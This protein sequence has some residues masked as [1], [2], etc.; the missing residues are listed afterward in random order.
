MNKNALMV[1]GALILVLI[2]LAITIINSKSPSEDV[3]RINAIVGN[4]T[5]LDASQ[6]RLNA[7]LEVDNFA[8]HK[9]QFDSPF[10]KLY[11]ADFD[12]FFHGRIENILNEMDEEVPP[13]EVRIWY[14]YNMGI[15]AKSSNCTV[16][17]DLAGTYIDP[18][19]V[20]LA[21]KLD[22]LIISHSHGDHFDQA[23]VKE[24]I[25]NNAT[26][27]FPG[28]NVVIEKMNGMFGTVPFI[29]R[30]ENGINPAN[31]I[32]QVY[33]INAQDITP[34]KSGETIDING[35]SITAFSA[36]HYIPEIPISEDDDPLFRNSSVSWF[37]VNIS[38]KTI[39]HTGDGFVLEDY[40]V[41]ADKQVDMMA[42]HYQDERSI[43]PY[44]EK[45]PNL[46]LIVPLHL[47]E[48]GHGMKIAEYGLYKHAL[49]NFEDGMFR[50]MA[51]NITTNVRYVPM[52]WG[53]S[54][55]LK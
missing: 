27:I 33:G 46:K 26:V 15:I 21:K 31:A 29:N 37:Y 42:I 20:L 22:V 17:F 14:V 24:A 28:E 25:R 18:S 55:E 40:E 52:I 6:A 8:M 54:I 50:L 16:G 10:P 36:K 1:T 44:Y 11:Q 35:I 30:D 41:G 47:H 4:T 39:L 13:G 32:E 51:R 7:L 53:E 38:G 19:I 43:E 2:V 12:T 34:L 9:F 5:P 23:V 3:N 45:I 49:N 48:F